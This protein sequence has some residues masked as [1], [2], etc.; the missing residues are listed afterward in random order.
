M[1]T[2]VAFL[3]ISLLYFFSF[4]LGCNY[5]VNFCS[6]LMGYLYILKQTSSYLAQ[7]MQAPC[8]MCEINDAV[9]ERLEL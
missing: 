5:L 3:N 6:M 2:F 7:T 9:H 4:H 8:I 1:C